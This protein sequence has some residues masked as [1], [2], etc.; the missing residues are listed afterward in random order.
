MRL[1]A[2]ALLVTS[3]L[4]GC[5]DDSGQRVSNHR[6]TVV[7][8]GGP[9]NGS[10]ASYNVR[11]FWSGWDDDGQVAHYEYAV[12]PPPAFSQWEI[13]SPERFPDIH[14]EVIPPASLGRSVP[15]QDTLLVFKT[16]NGVPSS[17]RWI[18]THEFGREFTFQTPDPDSEVS[19]G[20]IV[21][22]EQFSGVHV[23]YVR[24]QDNEGAYSDA[25]LST[26]GDTLEADYIGYTAIT[27]TPT[28][29]ILFPAL[30]GAIGL[31][32]ATL[33]AQW[34]G[35]D[36]DA[37]GPIKNPVGFFY[38]LV[39]L[40][41]LNPP[42]SV[43][44]VAP[45]LLNRFG[46]WTYVPGESLSTII[47]LAVPGEYIFGVRAV[48]LVGA[49]EPILQLG[50]NVVKFQ[51]SPRGAKPTLC[52]QE[53]NIEPA[54]FRGTG[55]PQE[56]E[57]PAHRKLHF[58]WSAVPD[59]VAGP[60]AA[61]SWG[62]DIPDIQVEGP[63]SGWSPWGPIQGAEP[64]IVFS[65][66]G[67]H[68]L[69][70]R[71]RDLAGSVT[72][73]Q[74]ILHV[75]EFSFDKE[76]LLVD[77]S[78][79]NLDPRDS[80]HDAFWHDMISF[81]VAHSDLSAGEFTEF[82][83]FGHGDRGNFSPIIPSLSNLSQYKLLIW[84]NSGWG[85]SAQ[86]GLIKA[87]AYSKSLSVYLRGGGKLWLSGSMTVG[88]TT[89]DSLGNGADLTYP[90][91]ELKPGDWTWDF[92]KL[93]STKIINDRGSDKRNLMHSVRSFAGSP[94]VYDTLVVDLDKVNGY[95][96]L[97]GGFAWADAVFD[98]I[99]ADAHPDFRGDI[100]TLYAYGAAGPEFQ[101]VIAPVYNNR[102]C[103]IRWHDPDPNRIQGRMQWFGFEFYYFQN[104]PAEQVFKKSLDWLR[105]EEPVLPSSASFP[106]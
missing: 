5:G 41:R 88:A 76:V 1:L 77:D 17:F 34:E 18:Q 99:Y 55:G 48:D 86:S 39:R 4:F 29:H 64:A 100:D 25:D 78:F 16:I 40:D 89:P 66:P 36:V 28:S 95:G 44:Y 81:Y 51:T 72:L 31:L 45:E 22:K 67:I 93:E 65:T 54:C 49:V 71:V 12:D 42:I 24:C 97:Y 32:G 46:Q 43:L 47:E 52:I 63:G 57:V 20:L 106:R 104:S 23:I 85:Y 15:G 70:V 58:T 8:K 73:A 14:I 79:D 13:A 103:A 21:P 87:T 27:Q 98:P 83:V 53:E 19:G 10:T 80:E 35:I 33:Y 101:G 7:I 91:T 30:G 82:D 60:I 37:P 6:P 105:E 74:L 84:N 61:F 11:I 9:L 75:F 102:L 38:N 90:K 94:V 59:S 26:G 92:L 2:V 56:V 69:Y 96:Q 68:V 62:L 3:G 50:R